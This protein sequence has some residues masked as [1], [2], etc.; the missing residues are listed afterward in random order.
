M[1][2][3]KLWLVIVGCWLL[4]A[5]GGPG[6][7]LIEF[8]GTTMGTTYS[9]KVVHAPDS[10]D[11]DQLNREIDRIL[12]Q[13]DQ[14]MST[15][16]PDSE[17]SRFNQ[18]DSTEWIDVSEELFLVIE[19]AL[20]VSLLTEGAFDITVGPLVNLWGFG[21]DMQTAD[22]PPDEDIAGALSRVGYGHIHIRNTPPAIRKDR[23]DIYL[24]LSALAKGYAVDKVA[25]YLE[26]LGISNYLV[27]VG[28]E[29]RLKGH[30]A[31]GKSWSIGIEKP[32]PGRR[33][34]QQIIQISDAGMA[35]SGDYRNFFEK[36]GKRYS[37]TISP[38]TGRPVTHTL[39]SVTVISESAMYAD[40][41]ATALLVLGPETG[42]QL[43]SREKLAA[44]FIAISPDGLVEKHTAQFDQY[45]LP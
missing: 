21:P 44:L 9:V 43:A 30:N 25:E 10:F 35:T 26:S 8:S 1:Q 7:E 22:L 36:D 2:P 37:H 18:S 29:L 13:I 31:R 28:G 12:E 17:L 32:S 11:P 5:C 6:E 20:R 40:A 34:V 24:D 14:K 23:A 33:T 45:L 41:M 27:D 42:Y 15:Y 16:D 39:A 4:A 3:V 38:R 19:E